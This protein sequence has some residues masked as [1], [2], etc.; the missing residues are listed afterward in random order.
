MHWLRWVSSAVRV[1]VGICLALA[2]AEVAL[3]VF[4]SPGEPPLPDVAADSLGS[5]AVAH[6]QIDEGVATSHFSVHGARLTGEPPVDSGNTAIVIG[7]SYVV[8]EQVA[9]EHT[10]GG[11]LERLARASGQAL[12]VRQYGWSGASPAQY[13]YAAPAILRRWNPRRVF[14]VVSGNDFDYSAVLWSVPRI[15][16]DSGE[17]LRIIGDPMPPRPPASMRSSVLLML[18]R[19]RWIVIRARGARAAAAEQGTVATAPPVV[20]AAPTETQPDSAEYERI[21]AAVI[22]ALANAYGN[23]LSVI[24]LANIGLRGDSTPEPAEAL[25]L[26]AC[27]RFEVDCVSS[28]RDMLEARR[29]GHVPNGLGIRTLGNG[30]LN[31]GGHEVVARLMWQRLSRGH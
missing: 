16:A 21:P 31:P 30:H 23:R 11:R 25:M 1:A 6:R 8:A 28:R 24:Y 7:D 22:R 5:R 14:V 29:E 13:I 18:A 12:D 2:A 15:R 20:D 9:D 27:A 4:V 17:T 19:H 26:S 3:R 10:M